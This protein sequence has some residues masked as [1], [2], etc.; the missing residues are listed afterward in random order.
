METRIKYIKKNTGY[1]YVVQVKRRL[2][3]KTIY[4]DAIFANVEKFIDT[5]AQI[6]EF[7]NK[8]KTLN[9]AVYE[10]YGVRGIF[11]SGQ[12]YGSLSFFTIYPKKTEGENGG[13]NWSGLHGDVLPLID[14]RLPK[15][16]GKECLD[17][18][19][20]RITIEQIEE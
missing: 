15:L 7:N 18:M 13:I 3:W 16:F 12:P 6:D 14:I 19:K 5:L 20:L 17:P 10:G 8:T 9:K 1:Y 2:F 4:T 11:P